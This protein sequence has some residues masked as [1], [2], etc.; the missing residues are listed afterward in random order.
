MAKITIE[1]SPSEVASALL[2]TDLPAVLEAT[3]DTKT[4]LQLAAG[5]TQEQIDRAVSDAL[6]NNDL[7]FPDTAEVTLVHDHPDGVAVVVVYTAELDFS[8]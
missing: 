2:K 8:D 3:R 4:G 7:G 1:L 6:D 5:V